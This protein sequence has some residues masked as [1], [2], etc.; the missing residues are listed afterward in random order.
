MK[1]I[2]LS[3]DLD[4]NE[5]FEKEVEDA[6]RAE[7]RKITRAEHLELI[8]TESSKEF[9]R[10]VDADLYCY[11]DK[12]K[13]I[14]EG[15]IYQNVRE[16]INSLELKEMINEAVN[17]RISSYSDCVDDKCK[18]VLEKTVTASVAKKLGDLLN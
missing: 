12:L 5:V 10:L 18:E 16:T 7:V 9:Q 6:I 4:D 17:L 1:R 3:I 14:V 2:T 13:K 8:K 11:K 15:V